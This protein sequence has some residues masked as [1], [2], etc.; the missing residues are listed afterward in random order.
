MQWRLPV[1]RP[2]G[3]R[4]STILGYRV[5]PILAELWEEQYLGSPVQLQMAA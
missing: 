4:L 5:P 3:R 1:A 2:N